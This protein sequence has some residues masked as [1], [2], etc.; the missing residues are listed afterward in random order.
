MKT[1]LITGSTSGIGLATAKRLYEEGHTVILNSPVESDISVLEQFD[2]NTRVKFFAAD[3]SQ[4]S[5]IEKLRDYIQQEFGRL[6]YLVANAGVLPLPAGVDTITEENIN[7]TID[8]NLKG[9]FNTLRILGKLIQETSKDGSIVALTSVDGII[10]EPYGVIYSA[11]KA[12]IISL[13]KSFART[14]K[15]PLVRVNAVA[16]GLID[17]PL[18]ATTGE[19]PS[20]TTDLSVI[21]RMGKPEEIAAVISFLLSDDASF[22]TGQV[23]A[24]D[25]GF[26]L[27]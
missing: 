12:G 6:D 20:W 19:E 3:I 23:L 7:K 10:G 16:P 24:V 18:T 11:S 15:E 26:T 4:P 25:G 9:T 1:A 14:Y 8:V 27:K 13:T 2:D 21:Q 5:S 22:V 17:T